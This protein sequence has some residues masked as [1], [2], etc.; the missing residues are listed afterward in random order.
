VDRVVAHAAAA[1]VVGVVI[2]GFVV[3]L[4]I[5]GFRDGWQVAFSTMASAVTLF[6]VFV[7]HHTQRRAQVATQLK[8][9]ELI[10]AL[11]QADDRYV[12]VQ[13]SADEEVQEL[14]QR[15]LERHRATRAG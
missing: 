4:A 13:T 9:D 3:A 1:A 15:H 11:P 14:E 10:R 7:V 8:L 12:H 5:A 2:V 6:M